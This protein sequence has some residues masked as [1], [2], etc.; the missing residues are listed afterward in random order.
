MIQAGF[1]ECDI[2]PPLGADRPC[3]FNKSKILKFSDPLK[4]RAL[5]LTDGTTKVA[6][7]GSDN[8]GCGP[9]FLR[10]LKK[11]CRGS[12]SST[13]RRIPITAAICATSSPASMRRTR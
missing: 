6:L 3:G 2:T 10:K 8:I 4:I 13:A 1:F 5:A 7:I 9:V 11:L 12:R